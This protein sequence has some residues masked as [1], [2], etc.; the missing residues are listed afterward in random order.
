MQNGRISRPS[1]SALFLH[2]S[3]PLL[4]LN[5]TPHLVSSLAARGHHHL[6]WNPRATRTSTAMHH[7]EHLLLQASDMEETLERPPPPCSHP[8]HPRRPSVS[9]SPL[10]PVAKARVSSNPHRGGD[11]GSPPSIS[12]LIR[13]TE[14]ADTDSVARGPLTAGSRW[15]VQALPPCLAPR[16][17]W[18]GSALLR[19]SSGRS[20]PRRIFLRKCSI[21]L[22]VM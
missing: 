17:I 22:F 13:R 4:D 16:W 14:S 10:S 19:P 11:D 2:P 6:Q 12:V 5:L 18:A 9:L 8:S 15:Q 21:I 3:L 7:L 1:P 20:G